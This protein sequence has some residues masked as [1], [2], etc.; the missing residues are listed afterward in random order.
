MG[1]GPPPAAA[2][3]FGGPG[4]VLVGIEHL[5]L[6]TAEPPKTTKFGEFWITS[7]ALG[8]REGCRFL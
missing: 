5:Q 3:K 4:G 2:T 8:K 7:C 6:A 1:T